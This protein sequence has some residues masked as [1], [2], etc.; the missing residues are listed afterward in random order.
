MVANNTVGPQHPT[1]RSDQALP[2]PKALRRALPRPGAPNQLT[3]DDS[4]RTYAEAFWIFAKTNPSLVKSG[5]VKVLVT[6]YRSQC[7]IP[8]DAVYPPVWLDSTT[9]RRDAKDRFVGIANNLHITAQGSRTTSKT[10]PAF[11]DDTMVKTTITSGKRAPFVYGRHARTYQE[12]T[13]TAS[14]A[15]TTT[16]TKTGTPETLATIADQGPTTPPVGFTDD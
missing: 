15:A 1:P 3:P 4:D 14:I 9:I 5:Q 7:A 10:L 12:A 16:T 11:A 6:A 13:A 2:S 8:D